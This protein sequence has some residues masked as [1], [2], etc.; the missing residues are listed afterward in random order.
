MSPVLLA[1]VVVL[2]LVGAVAAGIVGRLRPDGDETRLVSIVAL[3][4]GLLA[5]L[6]L[7]F[8]GPTAELDL[9]WI[10]PL[11]VRFHLAADG[12]S[13]PLVILSFGMGLVAIAASWWEIRRRVGF[14]HLNLLALLAGVILVFLAMDLV[15]FY[16]AWE[17][18]LIPMVLLIGIWGHA[19]RVRAA[20]KFFLFTQASGL[21]L[22]VAILG[23]HF[24]HLADTGVSSF[25]YPAL[26]GTRM[27]PAIQTWLL[28]GFFVAFATKMPLFPLHPWLPDAHTEAPTGGSVVLAGLLLKTG[29]YGMI[30]FAVPLFPDAAAALGPL[31]MTLGLV[32]VLYGAWLAAVQTDAKR[33]VAYTSVSHMGFVG[34]AVFA[35]TPLALQGAL[36]EMICHALSTGALFVVVGALDHRTG[37][38]DLRRLGGLWAQMPRFGAATLFFALAALGLPGLGNFVAEFLCLLGAWPVQPVIAGLGTL[39]L[40]GAAVYALWLVQ[41]TFH[42]RLLLDS[43]SPDLRPGE[44]S[45][46]G[47]LAVLLLW[48]GLFP[49]LVIDRAEAPIGALVYQEEGR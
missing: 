42:G 48:L 25:D 27:S 17:L 24:A 30:R 32:G 36:L 43:T 10:P 33:L 7:W 1:L 26:L 47:I 34:I 37:T 3:V 45:L 49:Q 39:G 40:V 16:F 9:P 14:F 18:M 5:S 6:G 11:A 44:V 13:L 35:W 2:P 38:R 46:Y 28:L 12:L 23:L 4:L 21:L 20:I 31:F 15:L 19:H 29:A 41:R 22:L 8:A